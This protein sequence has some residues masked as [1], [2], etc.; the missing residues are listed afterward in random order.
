MK[1]CLT[2]LLIKG[3]QIKTTMRYHD[4]LTRKAI[5]NYFAE[6]G[7]IP[8]TGEVVQQT[9]LLHIVHEYAKQY[10]QLLKPD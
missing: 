10:S 8:S 3:M 1:K 9:E 2:S 5:L 6:K 7:I 4:T